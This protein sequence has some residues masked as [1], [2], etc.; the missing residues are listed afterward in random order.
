MKINK[1]LTT[2]ASIYELFSFWQ[3]GQVITQEPVRDHLNA[4][5][6]HVA[7]FIHL[8]IS[9]WVRHRC[10]DNNDAFFIT[11][12]AF[13]TTKCKQ[14]SILKDFKCINL[15]CTKYYEKALIFFSHII[16]YLSLSG[17]T[18]NIRPKEDKCVEVGIQGTYDEETRNC[19]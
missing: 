12:S 7:F 5:H 15:L 3:I 16:Q 2:L 8:K 6:R 10:Y 11:F 14:T 9:C 19:M 1:R 13:R 4:R 17:V 18:F